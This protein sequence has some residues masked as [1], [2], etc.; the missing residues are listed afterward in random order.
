MPAD[1]YT[2]RSGM[3]MVGDYHIQRLTQ[4]QVTETLDT[5]SDWGDSGTTAE[6]GLNLGF[7]N[8]APGR[9]GATISCEGKYVSTEP[10]STSLVRPEMLVLLYCYIVTGIFWTFP[11]AYCTDFSLMV[12]IDTEEVVGWTGEFA[13]DGPYYRP[14]ETA[15]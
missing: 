1:I 5:R 8:R 12:N 10:T 4:W 7:T 6:Q 3:M 2:G 11:R 13:N 15:P 9:K 14:G